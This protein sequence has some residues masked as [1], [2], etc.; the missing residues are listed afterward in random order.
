MYVKVLGR[1]HILREPL[2]TLNP[3]QMSAQSQAVYDLSNSVTPTVYT[4]SGGSIPITALR[5]YG[6]GARF[7]PGTKGVFYFRQGVPPIA[8]GLRFRLCNTIS[9]FH[10]GKDLTNSLGHYFHISLYKIMKLKSW[11][12]L[13]KH[14][15]QEG[16]VDQQLVTDI[17]QLPNFSQSSFEAVYLYE[18]DQP[19][20]VDL[21]TLILRTYLVTRTHFRRIRVRIP[22]GASRPLFQGRH[23]Y[24]F[25][26]E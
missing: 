15:I 10:N 13:R 20:I 22:F 23:S 26:D 4:T 3:E 9:E 17:D 6:D 7:P 8:G 19:F 1:P 5:C 21:T 16:L 11:E 2:V 14:L 24:F 25:P 18:I 12:T